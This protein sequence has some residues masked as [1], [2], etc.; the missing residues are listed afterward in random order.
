MYNIVF[1]T[2]K[3]GR[4]GAFQKYPEQAVVT[5]E[6][7]KE[8][9]KSRRILF[10][11]SAATLLN[12]Q[13]GFNEELIF[14][15]LEADEN[16]H[17]RLFVANTSDHP[18]LSDEL[19]YR[20]SKNP[21]LY[22]DGK[23]RGKAISS[24]K[25]AEEV[26]EFLEVD[27]YVQHEYKLEAFD[28]GGTNM[29]LYEFVKIADGTHHANTEATTVENEE[30]PQYEVSSEDATAEAAKLAS[31]ANIDTDGEDDD[32]KLEKELDQVN[33]HMGISVED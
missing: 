25:L 32:F 26:A 8:A 30:A 18:E 27:G 2:I 12:L 15:F 31:Q 6:G 19:T 9:N 3:A 21:V 11:N 5:L 7:V 16:G 23:E 22:E 33:S 10:N 28:L 14:G 20:V 13:K 1:G 4:S 29:E 17:R 24:K